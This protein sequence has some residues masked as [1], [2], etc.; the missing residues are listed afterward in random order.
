M[1]FL[2]VL[3]AIVVIATPILAIAAFVR[4]QRLNEQLRAFPLQDLVSRIHVLEGHLSTLEKLL[5]SREPAATPRP[6]PEKSAPS[7]SP[8]AASPPP[9]IQVPPPPLPSLEVPRP[10]D[11]SFP[12]PQVNVF[13][14]PPL[15]SS[16][17]KSSSA[18]DLETLIGG[19]WLNRIGIIGL[20]SAVTFFLKY[21][22]DN[23][24][25]GPGGRVAIG[26]LLGAAMLPW[27]QWLLNRGYAYFSEG[28]AGLGAAVLY[29]SIWA[30]CQ[31]YKLFSLDVGFL[32]MIVITAAMA[33][34]ALGRNSQRIA[35]LSLF[36]GFLTPIL[37][38]QGKDAQVVLFTYVLILGAGL[39]A[40]E[41]RR[42][43]RTLTPLSFLLSQCYFWGW[44]SEFY[45]PNKL[46]RTVFFATLFFLLY[47][48]LPILRAVRF[49]K[50]EELDI[51]VVLANAFA[52][53][54][55]L[56]VML[57]PQDRW[58]LTL[59]VLALSAA[60]VIVARLVPPP[61][62]SESPLT[63]LLFAGMALTFATLA[64]PIRLDGKWIT[65]AFAVEGAVLVWTGFR[66]VTGFLRMGGYF[67]L[68]LAA[69]R[70]LIFP[71]PAPQFLFNE[72][73]AAYVVLIIC[74]GIVLYAARENA[75]SIERDERNLLSLFAV[76][77]NFFALFA[78]SLELW[79]HFGSHAGLGIDSGL[80]Q[81]LSLSLFWTAYAS[82]LI[83]LGV[84]RES[85]LLRWQAL[86]LFGLVIV[87][88]FLY[89]SS[90]LE[91]FYRIV[92]FAILSLVLLVVSFLYQRKVAH[93][94]SPS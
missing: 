84:V 72:R 60:H 85:A 83:A 82:G 41:M 25:I 36:G 2:G 90:Y 54:G 28:I 44:Y 87:K 92:S 34:V 42:D 81:Q 4:V 71:L 9:P 74:L 49:S 47:A 10:R 43:W 65:L 21:A 67:L 27:S 40:I 7:P 38:S 94:R 61:K 59:L 1:E 8:A 30:G 73:F 55:A 78:L 20:I 88:V 14:A 46:E 69:V 39:L 57:W 91:R 66:S 86:V 64:I 37:V 76:A 70:L 53:L 6:M 22:F 29:L 80:A 89:D 13:A 24:W 75:S 52:Y 17:P 58:P 19:R 32:A 62:S 15:H 50:L 16:Q 23:N 56:Y 45:R 93:G 5:G 35:L 31:Y 33:A 51:L 77:I 48:A 68:A 3:A 12:P 63:R 79:D 26:V 11:A 18:L